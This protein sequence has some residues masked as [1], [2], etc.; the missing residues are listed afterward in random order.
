MSTLVELSIEREERKISLCNELKVKITSFCDLRTRIVLFN[1]SVGWRDA[2]KFF[3]LESNS[4]QRFGQHS[5]NESSFLLFVVFSEEFISDSSFDLGAISCVEQKGRVKI[6]VKSF[7]MSA[8]VLLKV[9][10]R[11]WIGLPKGVKM[12]SL[13]LSEADIKSFLSPLNNLFYFNGFKRSNAHLSF[14]REVFSQLKHFAVAFELF[15][16]ARVFTPTFDFATM[17]DY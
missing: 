2:V 9:S 8:P 6:G 10:G 12:S 7:F 17:I 16:D 15:S 11:C 1:V 5:V 4:R 13:W 14:S 3:P